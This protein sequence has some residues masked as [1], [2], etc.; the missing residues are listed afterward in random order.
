MCVCVCVLWG[1]AKPQT[2]KACWEGGVRGESCGFLRL[3]CPPTAIAVAPTPLQALAG[4]AF[5]HSWIVRFEGQK[6]AIHRHQ[7]TRCHTS[8]ARLHMHVRC[9][10]MCGVFLVPVCSVMWPCCVAVPVNLLPPK[11]QSLEEDT[12]EE[13]GQGEGA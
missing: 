2:C 6:V 5:G 8:M 7:I 12:G 9:T 13:K 11:R 4:F 1:D 10:C 3:E